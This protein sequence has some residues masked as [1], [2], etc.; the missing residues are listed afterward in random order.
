MEE[1]TQEVIPSNIGQVFMENWLSIVVVL[2][3]LIVVIIIVKFIYR[4]TTKVFEQ[5]ISDD[6]MEIKKR[7]Y[8]VTSV[9]TNVVIVGS[10]LVALMIIGTQLGINVTPLLA[11]AG[12]AGIVIGFGA[13]S[14]IKDLING[15]FILFEQW[16][17]VNDIVTVDN[18]SGVVEK[19]NLRTTVLRDL[20]GT[21]HYIP[22]GE[23]KMLSNRTHVWTRAMIE[24]RSPLQR[25]YRPGSR[26]N[27]TGF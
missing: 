10:I 19:F 23:I 1:E 15:S 26:G 4:K 13:Q 24:V 21:A 14:L 22:N 11:G 2:A 25:K 17:Q 9:F 3:V 6:R 18:T 16:F 20:E 8:T 7:S 12:V 27:G 5:H